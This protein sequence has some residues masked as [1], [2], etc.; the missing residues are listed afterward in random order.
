[1]NVRILLAT[2]DPEELLFWEQ[3]LEDVQTDRHWR[4]WVR[5]D[6]PHTQ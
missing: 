1:M 5:I 3:V 6:P 2:S 4:G